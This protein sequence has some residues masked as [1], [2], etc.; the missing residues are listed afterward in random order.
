ML[1]VIFVTYVKIKTMDANT[2][3]FRA[4]LLDLVADKAEGIFSPP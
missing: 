1:L 3:V 2:S 4:A